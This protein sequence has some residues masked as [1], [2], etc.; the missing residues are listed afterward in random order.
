MAFLDEH[1]VKYSTYINPNRA[2]GF[3]LTDDELESLFAEDNSGLGRGSTRSKDFSNCYIVHG[4][5]AFLPRIIAAWGGAAQG[6]RTFQ[7]AT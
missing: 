7:T 2:H 1:N 6:Q 3:F 5:L 4:D